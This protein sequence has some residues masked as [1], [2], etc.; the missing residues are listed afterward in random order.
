MVSDNDDRLPPRVEQPAN[1]LGDEVQLLVDEVCKRMSVECPSE[2]I[3]FVWRPCFSGR[4]PT[5]AASH[6]R[7]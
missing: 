5:L 4:I 2:S 7:N 3:E 1:A 6:S